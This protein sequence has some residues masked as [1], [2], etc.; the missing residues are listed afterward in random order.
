MIPETA[1]FEASVR[2]FD[3]GVRRKVR[4]IAHQVCQGIAD[5]HGVEV[6]IEYVEECPVTLNDSGATAFAFE[7]ASEL[8]GD[9]RTFTLPRPLTG[10]EDFSRVLERVP[11]AMVL[12]GACPDGH[13]LDTAPSNHS[14]HAVFDDSVLADGAALYSQ[15]A[16][17]S[18][19]QN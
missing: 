4:E 10:T 18:L 7:T 1:G 3:R 6:V 12:I 19:K 14:P 2:T 13:D 17:R 11:G 15:L 5:A 16:L 8:F 9:S